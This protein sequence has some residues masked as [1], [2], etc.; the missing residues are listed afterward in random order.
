MPLE[1]ACP[2]CHKM[3][4]AHDGLLGGDA[5]CPYCRAVVKVPAEA[6]AIETEAVS[7]IMPA[8]SE[9]LVE[10]NVVVDTPTPVI[11]PVVSASTDDE[12]P[13]MPPTFDPEPVESAPQSV[14]DEGQ[15]IVE[16]TVEPTVE[17]IVEPVVEP[18]GAQPAATAEP[19][20]G[21]ALWWAQT[22]DGQ[23]Y[24][25]VPKAELDSW[26]ADGSINAECQVLRE[27]D[28]QWQ[29]ASQVYPQLQ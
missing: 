23:Q 6:S 25:P 20:V 24:G 11:E 22:A 19:V 26:V 16:P 3:L 21:E 29:W 14:T 4:R 7:D 2:V 18:V 8:A 10:N 13:L 28:P 12:E 15:P 27:G 1:L 9:D 17:P 5:L